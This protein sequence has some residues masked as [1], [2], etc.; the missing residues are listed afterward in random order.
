MKIL[1]IGLTSFALVAC[2]GGGGASTQQNPPTSAPLTVSGTAATGLA[3]PG[4]I[5]NSKC[6]AGTGTATTQADGSYVL[7][8]TGGQL[9]CILEIINPVDGVKL[10]TV[11]TGTGSSATANITPLTEMTTARV[12]GIEPNVFFATFDAS[13]ATQKITPTN[14][15]AAL[16]D[17]GLVLNGTVDI[18]L[19]GNF[20]SAP[21]NAAT[22]SSPLTGDAHD[23][24]LDALKL[25]I[26]SIQIGMLATALTSNQTVNDIKIILANMTGSGISAPVAPVAN[27]GADQNV[28]NGTTVTLDASKSS[29][30]TG[31][32]LTYLWTL[33]SKPTG[34]TATMVAPTGVK[35]TFVADMTGAYI[36]TVVVNDGITAS[37]AATVTITSSVAN[38]APIANAGIQQ[39]VISGMVVSINGSLSSDANGDALT[40]NWTLSSKPS[41][42]TAILSSTT[43]V[44]PTITVDLSGTYVITLVV[45]DGKINSTPAT[46]TVIVTSPTVISGTQTSDSV[47][48]SGVYLLDG[49]VSIP[50]SVTLTIMPGVKIIGK[51]S[52]LIVAGTLIANGTKNSNIVLTSM[53]TT[54]TGVNARSYSGIVLSN[55]SSSSISYVTIE[56]SNVALSL[57][58]I[59]V[60]ALRNVTFKN[61]GIAITDSG[62]YQAMD[63]QY[64]SFIGNDSAFEGLRTSGGTF[65]WN[66]FQNN[67]NVF[68]YGYYFGQVNINNNNFVGSTLVVR[69]PEVGYGYGS[70]DMTNNW[71]GS[72]SSQVINAMIFDLLDLG[73][74]QQISF[75]P[76]LQA[77]LLAG[78]G[79]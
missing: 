63:V 14:V 50:P 72:T 67:A 27:A 51:N 74:L 66:D 24:L 58:G 18:S 39:N 71:W 44:N 46:T 40:Y 8:V 53:P 3:I 48:S 49:I 56:N 55:S 7:T 41:G 43:A 60:I 35:P 64:C 31:K 32:S 23:K 29:S 76:L 9:P 54:S 6:I 79:L 75:T 16:T 20:M 42:S 13:I 19:L 73:T 33:A 70:L 78:A 68:K 45:N 52:Q 1:A 21:L 2:G 65:A 37:S 59:S 77:P 22:Q 26:S 11:V 28:V 61:N 17:V 12:L 36:A 4:A 34:S 38:A 69:A 15:Q 30:D 62:G 47:W 57:D 25:K 5:V 10:H